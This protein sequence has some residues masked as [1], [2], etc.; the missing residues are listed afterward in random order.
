MGKEHQL[1]K[2]KSFSLNFA[3][4]IGWLLNAV[5]ISTYQQ[6]ISRSPSSTTKAHILYF[7][8]H[9]LS[10]GFLSSFLNMKWVMGLMQM[11]VFFVKTQFWPKKSS[12]SL[13]RELS[14]PSLWS[15]DFVGLQLFT[16]GTMFLIFYCAQYIF[17]TVDITSATSELIHIHYLY[18]N[19]MHYHRCHYY[20]CVCLSLEQI[21]SVIV[22]VHTK[23]WRFSGFRGSC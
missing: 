4:Q 21:L 2:S 20:V 9:L 8:F 6:S 11:Q 10:F 12:V 5:N 22:N 3:P 17:A 16:Y 15:F 18:W 7:C 14:L 23:Y 1:C 13:E 19:H